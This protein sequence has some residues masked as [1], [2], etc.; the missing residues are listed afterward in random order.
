MITVLE[1]GRFTS[2]QDGGRIGFAHL[3]VPRA[4]AADSLSLRQAN[5]LVGNPEDAPALEITLSG[6]SLRFEVD[7]VMAF[8][9]GQ[10]DAQLDDEPLT[11]YQSIAVRAG[12]IL[13]CRALRT[14]M[15]TYLAIAGGFSLPP[16][17][18]SVCSDTLA[19]LGPSVLHGGERLDIRP[20]RL[21]QGWYWR[22][23]P[24]FGDRS[25]VRVVVGPHVHCFSSDT[26]A[27]F[28]RAEFA[29]RSDSDRS[30]LRLAGMRVPR[31]NQAELRSQGMVSGAVQIPGDGH[32]IVL[33]CNHGATGGYPVIATVITADLPR[34]GQ[35]RPGGK[36]CFQP[37][38]RE[39]AVEAL[40]VAQADFRNGLVSA[41]P[42]LL[43][44]RNLMALAKSYPALRAASLQVDGRHVRLRR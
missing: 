34:L 16:V 37:V 30:G 5:L 25:A 31:S 12:Q 43:T 28:L 6:P 39:Q 41:D 44:A 36:L 10:L 18:G 13:N 42:G 20:H 3:G 27:E 1:P 23:P 32:P 2:F 14:G 4:G 19:G 9:G 24:E 26:L 22:A 33:L 40:R 11:M 17:L 35:L 38:S 29:V 21:E 8:A 7:A 15:R